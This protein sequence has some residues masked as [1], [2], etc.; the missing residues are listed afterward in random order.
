MRFLVLGAV[1]A[2]A[3]CDTTTLG[4]SFVFGSDGARVTPEISGTSGKTR[5]TVAFDL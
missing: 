1:L 4:G 5:G 3:A 2:L